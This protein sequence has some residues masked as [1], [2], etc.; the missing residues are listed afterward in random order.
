MQTKNLQ[1]RM[2]PNYFIGIQYLC[3]KLC[4][5]YPIYI[6]FRCRKHILFCSFNGKSDNEDIFD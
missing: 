3:M 6:L 4:N 5:K 2:N 1:V